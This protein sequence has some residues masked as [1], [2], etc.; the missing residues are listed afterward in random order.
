MHMCVCEYIYM[1]VHYVNACLC[2]Y[3]FVC[4]GIVCVFMS[5][6]VWVLCVCACLCRY[7]GG[8]VFVCVCVC[9]VWVLCVC[10]CLYGGIVCVCAYLFV[11]GY[12]VFVFVCG[13]FCVCVLCLGIACVCACLCVGYCVCV[14]VLCLGIVC[15]CVDIICVCMFLWGYCVW[16][17][18]YVCVLVCVYKLSTED[19]LKHSLAGPAG[20]GEGNGEESGLRVVSLFCITRALESSWALCHPC[21]DQ[22]TSHPAL[23]C[24]HSGEDAKKCF[25]TDCLPSFCPRGQM[26]EV[27]DGAAIPRLS[28]R[29]SA[30][31]HQP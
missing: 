16:R 17:V 21:S 7:C 9:Y 22:G 20:H 2:V 11:C 8:G 1:Y 28:S 12:Y 29:L 15:V 27:S 3:V 26:E 24:S 30:P 6:Y 10:A 13:V 31:N 4:G 14:C 25:F 19:W 18:Y 23:V 5:V